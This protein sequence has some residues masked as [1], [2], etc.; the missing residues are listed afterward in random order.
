MSEQKKEYSKLCLAGFI[1]YFTPAIVLLLGILTGGGF[2]TE[3]VLP[4]AMIICPVLG[5]IFS[6]AG[7]VTARK[8]GKKGKGFGIAG[9]VLHG[10]AAFI[11]FVLV[12]PLFISTA[13]ESARMKK[14]E[15]FSMGSVGKTSN[16]EYDVSQCLL[17]QGYDL[18][19]LNITVSETEFKT[20]AESKL[21]TVSKSTDKSIRGTYQDYNFLIV[22]S[23]RLDEWLSA[24]CPGGFINYNGHLA[25]VYSVPWE[26]AATKPAFLSVYKDPSDKFIVITNCCDYKVISEF[27][28]LT[29]NY[30]D[31]ALTTEESNEETGTGENAQV[32]YLKQNIDADMTLLDIINVFEVMCFQQPL[33]ND[34]IILR[35]GIEKFGFYDFAAK[36][37]EY[38]G[39]CLIREF[40]GEDGKIYQI[41]VDVLSG[42]NMQSRSFDLTQVSNTD[43]DGDFFTYILKSDAYKYA[44]TAKI[45]R[46][47]I[48]ITEV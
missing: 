32:T 33:D 9:V 25:A 46:I 3:E 18:S 45:K 13:S 36:T 41:R 2:F 8:N 39:F 43:V 34:K 5:L 6:I 4:S 47:H 27:F 16:T 35:Y 14:N 30:V 24:N 10:I 11:I 40:T 1:L 21:T 42:I 19:S 29:D 22:R 48:Y 37:D 17:P 38:F 23:D 44:K 26:F 31:P 28:G 20:Y 7:I 15:M 12:G